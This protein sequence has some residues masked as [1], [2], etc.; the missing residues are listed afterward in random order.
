MPRGQRERT[1][2]TM[3]RTRRV[4]AALAVALAVA[5]TSVGAWAAALSYR[6]AVEGL[7]CPFCAYGVEKK[8]RALEG[9]ERAETH[10]KEGAVIVTMADGAT[11]NEETARQAVE[12]AG[13]TLKGFEPVDSR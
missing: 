4:I 1:G 6:L 5:W 11:L 13:F 2:M 9:V 7:A 12:A 8:L 3:Q 10:L